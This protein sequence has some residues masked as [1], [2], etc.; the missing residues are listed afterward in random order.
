MRKAAEFL[1]QPP[2]AVMAPASRAAEITVGL[3]VTVVGVIFA[4][5]AAWIIY[6]LIRHHVTDEKLAYAFVAAS[7]GCAWLAFRIAIKLLR[8]NRQ[9]SERLL[10]VRGIQ[11]VGILFLASPLLS[12]PLFLKGRP[13][14][15]NEIVS[16]IFGPVFGYWCLKAAQHYKQKAGG[17]L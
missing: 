15:P 5:L 7:L 1:P 8:R 14:D 4:A 16:L 11:I 17:S 3:I 6:I 13:L 10:P 12:V 9:K 2:P